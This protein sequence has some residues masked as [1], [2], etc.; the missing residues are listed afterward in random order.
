MVIKNIYAT[1]MFLQLA[2]D[3]TG[4]TAIRADLI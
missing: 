4:S 1:A 3:A 2:K